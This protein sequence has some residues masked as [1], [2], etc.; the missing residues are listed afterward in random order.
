MSYTVSF[1]F[2]NV[3]WQLPQAD[4]FRQREHIRHHHFS[5][6]TK[7]FRF[8]LCK[9]H[10][11]MDGIVP[12]KADMVSK[13][14]ESFRQYAVSD[15][16]FNSRCQI[17]GGLRKL[18]FKS[19]IQYFSVHGA[20]RVRVL[21]DAVLG[22]FIK[23]FSIFRNIPG[24]IRL[25]RSRIECHKCIRVWCVRK[26]GSDCHH[27][28]STFFVVTHSK[29]GAPVLRVEGS[30]RSAIPRNRKSDFLTPAVRAIM[31]KICHV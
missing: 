16:H 12:A 21:R 24:N 23:S 7:F 27:R 2:R 31:R 14:P 3:W 28:H 13:I 6:E 29:P 26:T 30:P 17:I 18:K 20:R 15:Q 5:E 19:D 22:L 8:F 1:F 9:R 25:W 4:H 11:I 10:G